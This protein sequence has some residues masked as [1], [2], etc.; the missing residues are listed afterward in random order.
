[1]APAGILLL[2]TKGAFGVVIHALAAL[3]VVIVVPSFPCSG[4]QLIGLINTIQNAYEAT[5]F[6]DQSS[7]GTQSVPVPQFGPR[8][9]FSEQR[10]S[11]DQ[12]QIPTGAAKFSA[13]S[14]WIS[15]DQLS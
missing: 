15:I 9:V 2:G 12:R 1:M 7:W 11:E 4:A 6:Q 5:H 8:I 3:L 13:C 10:T 14:K